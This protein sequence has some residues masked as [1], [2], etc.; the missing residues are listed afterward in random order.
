MANQQTT[1]EC[2][3][4]WRTNNRQQKRG[5]AL[6]SRGNLKRK[7]IET[8]FIYAFGRS[9]VFDGGS[10]IGVVSGASNR[11]VLVKW[12]INKTDNRTEAENCRTER[13]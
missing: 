10:V 7:L 5:R 1:Q 3:P 6:Q 2:L 9:V 4:Q 13:K 8:D 11:N 12:R